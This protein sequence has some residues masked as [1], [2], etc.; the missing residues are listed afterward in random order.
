MPSDNVMNYASTNLVG[1]FFHWASSF[2][3]LHSFSSFTSFLSSSFLLSPFFLSVLFPSSD[4]IPHILG[5]FLVFHFNPYYIILYF[6]HLYPFQ[7]TPL[8]ELPL[9]IVFPVLELWPPSY[10]LTT[11]GQNNTRAINLKRKECEHGCVMFY[12]IAF[13]LTRLESICLL[14]I[15]VCVF[16][17]VFI[18]TD[19]TGGRRMKF[20][21]ACLRGYGSCFDE[22]KNSLGMDG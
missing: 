13:V 12:N 11:C 14:C 10:S 18:A 8:S 17:Q 16:R 4:F 2:L 21:R 7:I 20:Y 1:F 9:Y 6:L 19:V 3:F 15:G 22:T 5:H